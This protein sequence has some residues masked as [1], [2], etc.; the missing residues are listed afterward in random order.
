MAPRRL[1]SVTNQEL[2]EDIK[3][4][5]IEVI[6]TTVF[7]LL[8]LGS[9][10]SAKLSVVATQGAGVAEFG[11]HSLDHNIYI[12]ASAGVSLLASA[13]MFYRITGGL[14]NPAVSLALR[15]IGQISTI[16]LVLYFIAQLTGAIIASAIIRG[17]TPEPFLIKTKLG[18]N[19]N[20]VQ[21]LFIEVFCTAIL[22][23]AIL[24]LAAEKSKLTPMAPI[25]ISM[26]LFA[27]HMFAVS[28]TGASLNPARSF[29]PSVVGGFGREHWIYWVGP[30]AGSCLS[31]VFYL[32]LKHTKY[33][34]I[35]P[36]QTAT[37]PSESPED[38]VK[39]IESDVEKDRRDHNTKGEAN[40]NHQDGAL[41]GEDNV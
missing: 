23:L 36:G 3:A 32:W 31:V 39:R 40:S 19:I 34:R 14:F 25:G 10:Q 6:G 41:R 26:T 15:L 13:W 38:P 27:C 12:S 11:P 35:N 24:M 33:W 18:E 17:V 29:G 16:R 8:A 4:A 9:I 22:I 30:L 20:L 28:F 7:L 21:G 5:S 1:F 2:R 37:D